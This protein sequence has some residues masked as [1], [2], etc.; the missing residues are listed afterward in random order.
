MLISNYIRET[1]LLSYNIYRGRKY[2]FMNQLALQY[3]DPTQ[4]HLSGTVNL[5]VDPKT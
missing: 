1:P 3:G 2:T 4:N 5:V